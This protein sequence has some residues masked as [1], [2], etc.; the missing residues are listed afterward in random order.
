MECK[1]QLYIGIDGIVSS[2]VPPDRAD[3]DEMIKPA[4]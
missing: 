2:A 3:P 4:E 1:T